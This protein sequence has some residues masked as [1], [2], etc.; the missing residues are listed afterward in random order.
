MATPSS[1][2]GSP[3]H[4]TVAVP[5]EA[6]LFVNDRPTTSLGA[7][8]HFA[9][10]ALEQGNQYGFRVRAEMMDKNGNWISETQQISMRAGDSETL[11][12]TF[13]DPPQLLA[14]SRK[15]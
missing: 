13:P 6:R 10:R 14:A 9:S 15:N 5:T 3:I 4:L 7:T 11:K 1:V 2:A 12:F 8:R